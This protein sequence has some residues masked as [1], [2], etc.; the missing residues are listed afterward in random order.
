MPA[1]VTGVWEGR[2]G[3]TK[4]QCG[5]E[6]KMMCV[7]GILVVSGCEGRPTMGEGENDTL[8]LVRPHLP[9]H[10]RLYWFV[11]PARPPEVLNM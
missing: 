10:T 11:R 9:T 2:E 8:G 6:G 4:C 7:G 5:S 3:G 1:R